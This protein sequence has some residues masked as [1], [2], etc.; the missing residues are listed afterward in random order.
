MRQ[1]LTIGNAPSLQDTSVCALGSA[2]ARGT[3]GRNVYRDL[4][5]PSEKSNIN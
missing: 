5:H 1:I 4:S 2:D 3:E